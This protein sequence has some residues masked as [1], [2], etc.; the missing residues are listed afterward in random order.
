MK[1]YVIYDSRAYTDIASAAVIDT[2]DT[3]E[4]AREAHEAQGSDGAIVEYDQVVKDGK[5]ELR[6]P[7]IVK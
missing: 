3:L 1:T 4:E 2:A 6:N 7:R 5:A